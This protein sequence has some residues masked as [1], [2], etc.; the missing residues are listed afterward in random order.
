MEWQYFLYYTKLFCWLKKCFKPVEDHG[1]SSAL[2]SKIGFVAISSV[3][4][5]RE[6]SCKT[7]L[8]T[9]DSYMLYYIC[10]WDWQDFFFNGA[11]P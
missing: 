3:W 9:I 10:D 11:L 2:W 4:G 6:P 5:F 8:N 7:W 1:S